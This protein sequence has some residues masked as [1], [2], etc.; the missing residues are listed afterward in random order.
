[1]IPVIGIGLGLFHA[2]FLQRERRI[3]NYNVELHQLVMLDQSRIA[4]GIAPLDTE[5]VHAMQEHVHPA[6]SMRGAVTLLAKERKIPLVGL[7]PHLDEKRPRTAGR[8]ANGV[9]F[10]RRQ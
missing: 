6:E 9:P 10:L 4:Q 3:G 5:T 2:P 7:T 8:I 1:M